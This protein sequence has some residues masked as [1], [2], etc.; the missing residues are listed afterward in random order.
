MLLADA[1]TSSKFESGEIYCFDI[2]LHL[3]AL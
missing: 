2:N 3:V 1:T